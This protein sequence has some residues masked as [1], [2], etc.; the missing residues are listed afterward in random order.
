MQALF[1]GFK[2]DLRKLRRRIECRA[3]FDED[4]FLAD[5][6]ENPVSESE[7]Y[8]RVIIC[9]IE[10]YFRDKTMDK[11]ALLRMLSLWE[12]DL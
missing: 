11:S 12:M 6:K 9:R 8:N 10:E 3:E 1:E 7:L 4:C 2:R 5:I